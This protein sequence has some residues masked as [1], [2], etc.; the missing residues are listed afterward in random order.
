M[1]KVL[2]HDER[3]SGNTPDWDR[4]MAFDVADDDPID[5]VLSWVNAAHVMMGKI[6]DLAI[7]CHGYVNP[8]NDM[9][10]HGLQLSKDGVF[11]SNIHKWRAINGFVNWI[12]VYAC[13]AADVDP[14]VAPAE[15][16]GRQL[17]R[18]MASVTG[19]RVVAALKTQYYNKSINPFHW[20]EIDFGTWEGPV[21]VF[22]PDGTIDDVSTLDLQPTG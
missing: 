17:C 9:G 3:L 4:T 21:Y 22:W 1:A 5:N 14:S 7:M 2:L 16:D 11:L 6:E 19:A 18:Q 15:G 10:G 13:N 20:R 8:A 12:F